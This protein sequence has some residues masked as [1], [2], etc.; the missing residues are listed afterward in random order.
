MTRREEPAPGSREGVVENT[1]EESMQQVPAPPCGQEHP[2]GLAACP[3]PPGLILPQGTQEEKPSP[4][5]I[6]SL[7]SLGR[8]EPFRREAHCPQRGS[9]SSRVLGR[10]R[11]QEAPGEIW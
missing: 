2:C 10:G 1:G 8:A 3:C 5:L 11:W 4:A 7:Q 6:L 9:A